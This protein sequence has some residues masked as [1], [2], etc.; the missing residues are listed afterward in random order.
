M[1]RQ[2]PLM[3]VATIFATNFSSSTSDLSISLCCRVSVQPNLL[4]GSSSALQSGS[5]L[6]KYCVSTKLLAALAVAYYIIII[7]R[8]FITQDTYDH[9]R[10]CSAV[11]NLCVKT[12]RIILL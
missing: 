6:L 2:T 12:A 11:K 8:T 3:L 1:E 4:Q 9:V 7:H 5:V 10:H